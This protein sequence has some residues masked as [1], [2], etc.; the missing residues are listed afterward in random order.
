MDIGGKLS[1][2]ESVSKSNCN[3]PFSILL[4]Y[5]VFIESKNYCLRVIT[6]CWNIN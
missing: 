2:S 6:L 4:S 5:Y 3:C 1:S